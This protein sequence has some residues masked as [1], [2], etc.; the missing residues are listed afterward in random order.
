MDAQALAATVANACAVG[1]P[2]CARGAG[3]KL[4]H[5]RDVPGEAALVDTRALDRILTHEP[6]E[7]VVHAEAGVRL[8]ALQAALA[9]HGQWLPIDPPYR[10]ATLGGAL[11]SGL[12]GPRRHA[13]G[14][15]K[16]FVLGLRVVNPEGNL[17]KSG[18]RVVKNVTG[19]D[20]HRLHVGAWGRLGVIVD[21]WLKVAPRP[22]A[23]GAVVA[24]AEDVAAAH[25]ALL[26]VAGSPLRPAALEVVSGDALAALRGAAPALPPGPALAIAAFEG[27]AALCER[28]RRDLPP[29][30][31]G[32]P[33]SLDDAATARL[34]PALAEIAERRRATIVVRVG[35][36]PH[37][38]GPLLAACQAAALGVQ[39]SSGV[40]VAR[41]ACDPAAGAGALAALVAA[42]SARASQRG[43]YAVVEAAPPDLSGREALP[44]GDEHPLEARVL[45]AWRP[46]AASPTGAPS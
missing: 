37:D 6:G 25:A 45:R 19:Y 31:G 44:W 21:A 27:S 38:L 23:A 34:W 43:G 3:T 30:L 4:H 9:H 5:L 18:G 2:V 17:V 26:R 24:A 28:H 42:W 46:G 12:A 40:G 41:I 13:Y 35:A 39:A 7:L 20:L 10:E 8:A 29:L 22:A 32:A 14:R 1:R 15:V 11:A 36:R 33:C 16:D